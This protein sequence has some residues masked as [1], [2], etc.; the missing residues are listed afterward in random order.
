MLYALL[1]I[2]IALLIYGLV[3]GFGLRE[4]FRMGLSGV[5]V[6]KNVFL[7]ML[8]VG[9]MTALWRASGTVAYIVSVT[10]GALKPAI[11]LPAAFVLNSLL[12]AL[13]GTSVGTAATMGSICM[14]VGTAMGISPAVCGGA[15]LSGAF[16]GDRCSPVSTSALLVAQVTGTNIYDNIRGMLKTCIV[17]FV[18]SLG[19]FSALGYL[20]G[21]APAETDVIQ[22]FGQFY[23]LHWILLVPA[24]TIL[25]L[26]IL[27]VDI[28]LNMAVSILISAVLV[29]KLQGVTPQAIC[30]TMVFGYSAPEEISK[31]LSGGGLLGMVKMC[32]TILIS[33][34]FV[35]LIKGTG[36]MEKVKALISRISHR[37]SPFGC[38]LFTAILTVMTSCNQT[39]SIVLTNEMC[40]SV[41]PDKNKR[42]LLMENSSVV[43]AGIIPW[44]M[45]SLVPLGAMGAPTLSVIFASYLFL[46]PL[47][48]WVSEKKTRRHNG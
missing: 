21:S 20:M 6:A 29:W 39:M 42:A 11:F 33:L 9:V 47:M 27:R 25:I 32:G 12:S 19:I 2:L 43:V 36:L 45:A 37:V 41:V 14:S 35:G 18:L 1:A 13:T 17:P 40:E 46:L 44:S 38:V 4:L 22:I 5:G 26:A 8:M 24:A 30:E 48:Q 15:V 34:T 28:K 10:S 31:M 16:F 7:V 3:R 23:E